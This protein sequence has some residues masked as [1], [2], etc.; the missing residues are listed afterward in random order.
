MMM[1][2][3]AAIVSIILISSLASCKTQKKVTDTNVMESVV[4][5]VMYDHSMDMLG[6]VK[7]STSIKNINATAVIGR[8]IVVYDTSLAVRDS[9]T[10]EWSAPVLYTIEEDGKTESETNEQSTTV[11]QD[12]ITSTHEVICATDSTGYE[13]HQTITEKKK[14]A[15]GWRAR[16]WVVICLSLIIAIILLWKFARTLK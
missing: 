8:K 6:S 7:S 10:G 1:R 14:E 11:E 4:N 16:L 9:V 13:K 5:R 12:T 2:L 15:F 3:C